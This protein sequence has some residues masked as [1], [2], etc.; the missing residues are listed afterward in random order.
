MITLQYEKETITI[1]Y[2]QNSVSVNLIIGALP[3]YN[4]YNSPYL[5]LVSHPNPLIAWSLKNH[6]YSQRFFLDHLVLSYIKQGNLVKLS[7]EAI[8]QVY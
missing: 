8:N 3:I 5:N 2:L 1:W 7:F 4:A 6:M